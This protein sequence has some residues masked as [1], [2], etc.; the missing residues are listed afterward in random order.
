MMTEKRNF[1]IHV[2][3]DGNLYAVFASE[4]EAYEHRHAF[5][6]YP[7]ACFDGYENAYQLTFD[8]TVKLHATKRPK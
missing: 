3:L 1:K 6:G 8:G 4:T 2:G 7:T 5:A